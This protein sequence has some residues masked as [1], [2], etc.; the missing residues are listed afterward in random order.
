MT[1]VSMFLRRLLFLLPLCVLEILVLQVNF[2]SIVFS[3]SVIAFLQQWLLWCL[4][5]VTIMVHYVFIERPEWKRNTAKMIAEQGRGDSEVTGLLRDESTPSDVESR[6]GSASPSKE[7]VETSVDADVDSE[8]NVGRSTASE[9][10]PFWELLWKDLQQ[11]KFPFELLVATSMFALLKQSIPNLKSLW[12]ASKTLM[13]A[14]HPHWNLTLLGTTVI[15]VV[16]I[17]T[18]VLCLR[19]HTRENSPP[20]RS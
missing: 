16:S 8:V 2:G 11:L 3:A 10:R 13:L 9:E 1:G 6:Y 17:I 19:T 4:F 18:L 7:D 14:A 12:P 20:G 5:A 15:V